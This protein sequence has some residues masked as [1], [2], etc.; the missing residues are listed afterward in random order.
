MNR[1][2]AKKWCKEITHWGNGGKLWYYM[3]KKWHI[4]K[5]T[6]FMLYHKDHYI[7]DDKHFEARKHFAL[8]GKVGIKVDGDIVDIADPTWV[9]DEYYI[10]AKPTW[11]SKLKRGS[12]LC[13][14]S[15]ENNTDKTMTAIITKYV[16]DKYSS[17]VADITWKY[18]TPILPEELS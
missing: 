17:N 11:H 18:A 5:G 6:L 7:I 3:D 13:W 15:D 16:N 12:V 2:Q 9:A 14:V 4:Y 1:E 8:D 10:L